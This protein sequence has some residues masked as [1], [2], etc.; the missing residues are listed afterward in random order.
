MRKLMLIELYDPHLSEILSTLLNP[1]EDSTDIHVHVGPPRFYEA[2]LSS[3]SNYDSCR[4]P[5]YS[6]FTFSYF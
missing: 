4:Y 1:F 5:A 6:Y 3:V 2:A